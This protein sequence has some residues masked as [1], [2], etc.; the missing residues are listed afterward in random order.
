MVAAGIGHSP[1]TQL[2]PQPRQRVLS[3]IFPE[4]MFSSDTNPAGFPYTSSS[5]DDDQLLAMLQQSTKLFGASPVHI[6]DSTTST[7]ILDSFPATLDTASGASLISPLDDAD[8]GDSSPSPPTTVQPSSLQN[9]SSF[10]FDSTMASRATR[11]ANRDGFTGEPAQK[12]KVL[13]DFD[14][15]SDDDEPQR[16]VQHTDATGMHFR[17]VFRPTRRP[18]ASSRVSPPVP[19]PYAN[20]IPSQTAKKTASK[21]KSIGGQVCRLCPYR[22]PLV[23]ASVRPLRGYIPQWTIWSIW[24]CPAVGVIGG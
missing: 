2:V 13:D 15:E 18:A 12:R 8:T 1:V 6:L 23:I 20:T 16:K 4:F 14:E 9:S 11:S 10:H 17:P 19:G 3:R 7:H 24:Q 22:S 21:R 5:M